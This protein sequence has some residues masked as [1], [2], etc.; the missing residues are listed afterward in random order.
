MAITLQCPSLSLKGANWQ[1]H[2]L[3]AKS[4]LTISKSSMQHLICNSE[5]NLYKISCKNTL[6][7]YFLMHL[8]K[9]FYFK[10]N[11]IF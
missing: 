11:L 1:N 5:A 10:N 9:I 8:I 7:K 2:T 6:L 3:V 4:E